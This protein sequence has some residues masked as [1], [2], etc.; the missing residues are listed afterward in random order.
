MT[1]AKK[2]DVN[3]YNIL[4]FHIS[5]AIGKNRLY[6]ENLSLNTTIIGGEGGVGTFAKSLIT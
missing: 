2:I 4:E 6:Q 3:M 5:E 1:Y